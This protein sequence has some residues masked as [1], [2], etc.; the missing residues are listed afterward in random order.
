MLSYTHQ[1][2]PFTERRSEL[3]VPQ[4][5]TFWATLPIYLNATQLLAPPRSKQSQTVKTPVAFVSDRLC[6]SLAD[7]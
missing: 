4:A 7:L 3:L 2:R 6:G 1:D 5:F